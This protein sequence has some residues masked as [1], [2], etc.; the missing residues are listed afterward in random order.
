MIDDN[1]YQTK[2][3]FVNEVN[4]TQTIDEAENKRVLCNVWAV[5]LIFLL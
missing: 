4:F 1:Q 3:V 5:K 2:I